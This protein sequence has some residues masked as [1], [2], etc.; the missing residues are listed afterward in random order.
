MAKREA[1][2]TNEEI[3]AEIGKFVEFLIVEAI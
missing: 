1:A 2:P 3:N